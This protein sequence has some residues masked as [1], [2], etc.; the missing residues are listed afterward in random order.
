MSILEYDKAVRDRIPELGRLD[1]EAA[2]C[3]AKQFFFRGAC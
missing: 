3:D 2:E 1:D